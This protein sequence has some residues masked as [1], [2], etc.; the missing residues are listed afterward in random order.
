MLDLRLYRLAFVPAALAIIVAAF[1]LQPRERGIAG[2]PLAPD[3]F[4]GRRAVAQLEALDSGYPDRRPGG[5]DDNRLAARVAGELRVGNVFA[6]SE[7]R[8]D[9][10]T[11]DG[12]RRLTTVVAVRQGLSQ[13]R[14]VVL[15]HRDAL[16]PRSTAALSGTA[17]LLELARVFRVGRSLRRTLVLVSTSG[18]TAGLAGAREFAQHP[19]GPVDA[20]LVLGDMAGTQTRR[21]LVVPFSNGLGAAPPRLTDTVRTAVRAEVGL[22][23]GGNRLPARFARLAFPLTLTEQGEV[24]PRSTPSVLLSASGE[25]GPGASSAVSRKRLQGFGRAALRSVTALDGARTAGSAP[26]ADLAVQTK[27][28]PGW[29]VRLVTGLLILPALLATVDGYARVR[30]RR[31]PVGMWLRWAL[32]GALPFLLAALVAWLLRITGLVVAPGA[33][34]PVGTVPAGGSGVAAL[35]AVG[36][37]LVA[38]WLGLRPLTL[39]ALGVG[40]KPESLGAAAALALV[41]VVTVSLVWLGNPYAAAVLLPALHVW[42]LA[43]EPESRL[44]RLAWALF[45]LAALLPLVVVGLYY[46]RVFAMGPGELVWMGFLLVAGGGVSIV[47]VVLWSLLGGCMLAVLAVLLRR[48]RPDAPEPAPTRGPMR[49]AGPGSLGGTESALRR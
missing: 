1:S 44:P 41:L 17:A 16:K 35:V 3:A 4:D 34:A 27:V 42:L 13:R 11:A 2:T 20:V 45:V 40:G 37:V 8:F 25:R 12:E 30:R 38:G 33:P 5:R 32:T 39:R 14:I 24:L 6:V 21:P 10:Q 19:G 18:G 36:L 23:P 49:Y 29:A 46:M 22:R 48:R 31:H 26:D 15:A 43:L 7:R 47:S 28:L 9:A